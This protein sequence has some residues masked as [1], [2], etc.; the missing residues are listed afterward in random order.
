MNFVEFT[1]FFEKRVT[2]GWTDRRTD[3]RMDRRTDK[4][5]YRIY[6]ISLNKGLSEE[7]DKDKIAERDRQ[8]RLQV[9]CCSIFAGVLQ[10][11]CRLFAGYL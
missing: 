2:H 11:V 7:R 6:R 8:I 10:V 5:S 1:F 9:A 3:R 4:A